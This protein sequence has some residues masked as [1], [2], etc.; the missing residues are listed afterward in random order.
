MSRL[1]GGSMKI[2]VYTSCSLNYYAKARALLESIRRNSPNT[3]VTLCLCDEL[4]GDCDPLA[5][6]FDRMWQPH[7]LGYSRAWVFQ[8]NVMELCTG[9]RSEEHTSELQS[10]MRIS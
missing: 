9:V 4:A 6:G 2:A 10:L 3:S 1:G 8:H 5:E 7:D